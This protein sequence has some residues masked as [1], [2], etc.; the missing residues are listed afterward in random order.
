MF[1]EGAQKLYAAIMVADFVA[2]EIEAGQKELDKEARRA[3]KELLR[4]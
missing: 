2:S 3:R 1:I 4:L